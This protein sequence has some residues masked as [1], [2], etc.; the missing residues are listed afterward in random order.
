MEEGYSFTLAS[1]L[2]GIDLTVQ[3]NVDPSVLDWSS[4]LSADRCE[5]D[6]IGEEIWKEV[7]SQLLQTGA[8]LCSQ[9]RER[10]EQGLAAVAL[11]W[12]DDRVRSLRLGHGS[13]LEPA[14][15]HGADRE[16]T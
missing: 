6:R 2:Q 1:H 14:V 12:M 15:E 7:E 16:K 8:E 13:R 10:I 5:D 3:L 4:M 9:G 11:K